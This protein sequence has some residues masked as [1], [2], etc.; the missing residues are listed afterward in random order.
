MD[1]RITIVL[2]GVNVEQDHDFIL[3][4]GHYLTA[5]QPWSDNPDVRVEIAAKTSDGT[6]DPRNHG[7]A[8]ERKSDGVA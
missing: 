2:H 4:L 1:T 7:V 6:P 8:S 3:A 5:D